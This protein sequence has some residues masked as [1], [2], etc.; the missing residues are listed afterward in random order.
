MYD[1]RSSLDY[2]GLFPYASAGA[3]ELRIGG[4]RGE[5]RNGGRR[6]KAFLEKKR[7]SSWER[8]APVFYYRD[9]LR[10]RVRSACWKPGVIVSSSVLLSGT[11]LH[12]LRFP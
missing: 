9:I 6:S 12:P 10:K 2:V 8:I 5:G 1:D 3:A 4:R 7:R 11:F